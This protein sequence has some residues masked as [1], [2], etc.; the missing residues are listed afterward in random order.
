[1]TIPDFNPEKIYLHRYSIIETT[2][3][4][5]IARTYSEAGEKRKAI[6]IYRQLLTF[7]EE[8]DQKLAGYATHFCLVSHNYAIDLGMEKRYEEAIEVANR[9]WQVSLEKGTYQYLPGFLAILAEC[10]F[11]T[12]SQEQSRELY[13]QAYCIYKAFKDKDN[14]AIM[15][16]EMK[17]RLG[18]E[19]P[20]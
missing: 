3:I 4:N 15:R 16:Q 12:G 17:E 11:F 14:L 1:M 9:G 2:I 7:I 13:I 19:P 10:Y 18:I 6:D 20:V 8:H 5:Q